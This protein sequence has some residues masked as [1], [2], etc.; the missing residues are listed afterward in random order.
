MSEFVNDILGNTSFT[1]SYEKKGGK[2]PTWNNKKLTVKRFFEIY[3]R[4]NLDNKHNMDIED[5][6]RYIRDNGLDRETV[7][8]ER[9]YTKSEVQEM[10]RQMQ[11]PKSLPIKK[12]NPKKPRKKNTPKDSYSKDEVAAILKGLGYNAN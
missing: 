7:Q 12:R 10:F 2:N 1:L 9:M 8:K 3:D 6:I 5:I 11:T 4:L